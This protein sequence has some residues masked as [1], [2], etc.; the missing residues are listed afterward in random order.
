VDIV[1]LC[2]VCLV[3][4]GLVVAVL[5][6][7]SCGQFLGIVEAGTSFLYLKKQNMLSTRLA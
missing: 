7:V 6:F 2:V 5:L 1:D 4:C 3:S